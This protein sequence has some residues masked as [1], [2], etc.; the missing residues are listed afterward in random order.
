MILESIIHTVSIPYAKYF[1]EQE[2]CLEN[3]SNFW[4]FFADVSSYLDFP[5]S[6]FTDV[7]SF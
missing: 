4:I 6:I 3:M 2:L 5:Q 7:L 1:S